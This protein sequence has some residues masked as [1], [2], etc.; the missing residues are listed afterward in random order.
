MGSVSVCGVDVVWLCDLSDFTFKE[1][2][3]HMYKRLKMC[4]FELLKQLLWSRHLASQFIL[5]P[6]L[7]WFL[8]WRLWHDSVLSSESYR[9]GLN[10]NNCP[11][12]QWGVPVLI[13]G[14]LLRAQAE[15][16]TIKHYMSGKKQKINNRYV[17]AY[18]FDVAFVKFPE[19]RQ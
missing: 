12:S 8:P 2:V 13:P 9:R 6:N 5:E 7:T 1:S 15:H 14:L 4:V 10:S 17:D 3:R 19:W 11:F 18:R 16:A